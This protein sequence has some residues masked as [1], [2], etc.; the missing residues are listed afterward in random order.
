MVELQGATG[1]ILCYLSSFNNIFG[2]EKCQVPLLHPNTNRM[3]HEDVVML[4]K[5]MEETGI[6]RNISKENLDSLKAY[7]LIEIS[8]GEEEHGSP[9]CKLTKKGRVMLKANTKADS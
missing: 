1:C 9:G 3:K 2:Q 7:K 8:K 4:L 5:N 6:A